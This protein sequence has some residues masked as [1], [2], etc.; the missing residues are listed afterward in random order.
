MCPDVPAVNSRAMPS[1]RR[2]FTLI[3]LLVVIA[4]IAILAALLLPAL[5]RAKDAGRKAACVSNLR[6][7]GIAIHAYAQDHAGRIPFGPP[8]PAFTHPAEFY[9]S[10]GSP[11]SLISLRSGAPVGLGLLLKDYLAAAPKVLFCPG[12]DQTMNAE[13][14]LAKVG[15]TQA[16][17]SYYYRHAGVTRL[18]YSPPD[19]VPNLQLDSLGDNRN[20]RPIRAL[21]LDS[22]FLCSGDVAIYGIKPSTHHRRKVANIL[23]SDGHVVAHAGQ[24]Q[25][26]TVDLRNNADLYDAFN[27]ILGVLEFAD[28]QF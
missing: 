19:P 23:F 28:E 11:T 5:A 9:P 8:A 21:A 17:G 10:T 2:A 18:F 16:Q 15:T 4:I 6:Q 12:S 14:E 13:V 1:G 22:Q 3:E 25:R 20:G 24:I 27:R 7:M 26:L